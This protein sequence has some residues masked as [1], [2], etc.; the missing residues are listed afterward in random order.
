MTFLSMNNNLFVNEKQA[1]SDWVSNEY[2]A[3]FRREIDA[4]SQ[5][6]KLSK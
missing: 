4:F 5:Y 1:I 2:I 6:L 3:I